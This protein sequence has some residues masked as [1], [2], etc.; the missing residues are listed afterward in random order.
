[1]EQLRY[2][3]D[4]VISAAEDFWDE[5]PTFIFYILLCLLILAVLYSLDIP[6]Y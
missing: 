4:I 5:L 3:V 1:M 2:V 6:T